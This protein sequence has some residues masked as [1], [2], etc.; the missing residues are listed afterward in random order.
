MWKAIGL[1]LDGMPITF[2]YT[3]IYWCLGSLSGL[4]IIRV[5]SKICPRKWD[6]FPEGG[7]AAAWQELKTQTTATGQQKD[8]AFKNFGV[9]SQW[10]VLGF[11]RRKL[12]KSGGELAKKN[13]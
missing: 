13:K 1:A 11:K 4:F 12:E 2:P 10:K 9:Q 3:D 8:G 7:G 5:G 6:K